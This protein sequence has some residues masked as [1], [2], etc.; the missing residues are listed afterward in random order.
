M[1]LEEAINNSSII[2]P[3][4]RAELTRYLDM[5]PD[6]VEDW[7]YHSEIV[8]P[9]SLI[10]GDIILNI[11]V[12]FIDDSGD[13][14]SGQDIVALISH[15]CDMQRERQDFI[16]IA[17]V[18]TFNEYKSLTNYENNK[19]SIDSLIADIRANKVFRYFYLPPKNG[20]PESFI[21]FSRMVSISSAFINSI[22]T[23]HSEDCILSLSQYGYYLFLIKL[24]FHLARMERSSNN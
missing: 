4:H 20:L 21:D 9:E 6:G 22:K 13:V 16:I 10:Q 19:Q 8:N 12:C 3:E 7:L 18:V 15:S 11:P 14:L 2:L 5:F 24:T 17:P 23:N 1:S